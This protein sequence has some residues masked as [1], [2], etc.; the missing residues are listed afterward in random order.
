LIDG[1]FDDVVDQD[2]D[3]GRVSAAPAGRLPWLPC[4]PP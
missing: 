3:F 2:E 4:P 1:E